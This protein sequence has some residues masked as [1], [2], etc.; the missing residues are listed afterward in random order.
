M[1]KMKVKTKKWLKVLGMV[2]AV[3]VT[4][5]AVTSLASKCEKE[6]TKQLGVFDYEIGALSDTDGKKIKDDK[7]GI[8][9]KDMYSIDGFTVELEKDADVMY[10]LN[11][12]DADKAWVSMETYKQDFDGDKAETLKAQ[13]IAYARVEIIP[14]ED[15][16]DKVSIFEKT[17][18]VKQVM[19]T[20][21]AEEEAEEEAETETESEKDT[22]TNESTE[23]E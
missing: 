1:A 12:Y 16:D 18:Y 8:V 5:G 7:S 15:E 23:E 11:F 10:Q 21:S 22:T 6:D 4:L 14:L 17:G 9:S 19:V 20:V 13:G 3:A 2:I